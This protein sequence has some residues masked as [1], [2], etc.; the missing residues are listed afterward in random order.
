MLPAIL[1]D[2]A[3]GHAV[4]AYR[5]LFKTN[6]RASISATVY[7]GEQVLLRRPANAEAANSPFTVRWEAGKAPEGW[8]R[9]VLSGYFFANNTP[10]DK[11]VR[12]SFPV[13]AVQ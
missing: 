9:L 1:F 13:K 2:A 12:F 4:E 8:Y 3:A 10:V 7:S 5:F 6:S 11:E